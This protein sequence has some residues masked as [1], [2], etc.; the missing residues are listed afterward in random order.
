MPKYIIL[1]ISLAIFFLAVLALA[2]KQNNG[3]LPDDFAIIVTVEVIVLVSL[4][5]ALKHLHN[6]RKGQ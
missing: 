3:N 6:K 4:F 5:F 2:I 1:P